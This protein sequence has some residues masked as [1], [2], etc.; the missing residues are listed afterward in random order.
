MQYFRGNLTRLRNLIAEKLPDGNDIYGYAGVTKA[1]LLS[2]LDSAYTLSHEITDNGDYQ[3]EVISLKRTGSELYKQLVS[4]LDDNGNVQKKQ[5]QFNDFL[6]TFM[7]L[8]E[9]IR[10]NYFVI[11]K[12]A[13]RDDQE[14]ADIRT[15]IEELQ[16]ASKELEANSS[17]IKTELETITSIVETIKGYHA[18]TDR[19]NSDIEKWHRTASENHEKL[20][21][22]YESIAGWDDEIERYK[23][24]FQ[25]YSKQISELSARNELNAVKLADY[26][27]QGERYVQDLNRT[28]EAHKEL[29]GEIRQTLAGANRVG[30]AASFDKRKKELRWQQ[31]IWQT[32]FIGATLA[33]VF[34]V[35]KFVLPTLTSDAGR[36]KELL[37]E[38]GIVSPLIWLGWFA[39]KQYGYT[40]RIREDYAFKSAAAMAYEGHKKAARESDPDLERVLLEFSLFNL[41]QNPI[42]LYGKAEM[43]GTPL[44][45]LID[46]IGHKL[47]KITRILAVAPAFGRLEA[48]TETKTGT[49]DE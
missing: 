37:A 43:H 28:S 15:R 49:T 34:I 44:H 41:S 31:S 8:I 25:T 27:T 1:A 23:V 40:S 22:I 48:E 12:K 13:I 46:Q 36:T 9:K 39:A 5:V 21:S 30:M 35:W 20:D 24:Q 42:R 45:E 33:I 19:F 7:A 17:D 10:I 3:F 26:T 6:F 4:F 11:V 29:L 38:L 47:P 2:S 14:I 16:D 18:S 32:A